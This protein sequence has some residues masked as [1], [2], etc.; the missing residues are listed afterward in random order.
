MAYFKDALTIVALFLSG[1]PSKKTYRHPQR[2]MLWEMIAHY[3]DRHSI[4]S[5]RIARTRSCHYTLHSKR[6]QDSWSTENTDLTFQTQL[7]SIPVIQ[8]P[9]CATEGLI[10][11]NRSGVSKLCQRAT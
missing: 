4:N 5:S 1:A 6:A 7:R 9:S 3:V 11:L 8:L 10:L 2:N